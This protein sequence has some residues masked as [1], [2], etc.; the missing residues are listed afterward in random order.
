M[1]LIVQG[2]KLSYNQ[3][4]NSNASVMRYKICIEYVY[5]Q[6]SDFLKEASTTL[7]E[8]TAN[9]R[10]QWFVERLDRFRQTSVVLGQV[11]TDFS[12]TPEL[13]LVTSPH[14]LACSA[15]FVQIVRSKVLYPC[16]KHFLLPNTGW[17]NAAL[18][19]FNHVQEAV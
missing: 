5:M 14:H 15:E 4:T 16:R 17:Q 12:V 2:G 1:G 8:M 7:L 19:L 18:Q 9:F 3:Q 10:G 11:Q 6:V 13:A